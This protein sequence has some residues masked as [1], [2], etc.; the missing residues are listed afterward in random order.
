[1]WRRRDRRTGAADHRPQ[2]RPEPEPK[3][4]PTPAP[5]RLQ[6]SSGAKSFASGGRISVGCQ[7]D[8]ASLRRCTATLKAG[9]KTLGR[10]AVTLTKPGASRATVRL[11]LSAAGVKAVK[12]A[13][14]KGLRATLSLSA[15][16]FDDSARLTA[17][18]PIRVTARS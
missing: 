5:R 4:D 14:T 3:P 13:G 8:R 1:M 15:Q 12:K 18:K 11:T 9:G 16:A 17:T 10:G 2:A 6:V 7:L